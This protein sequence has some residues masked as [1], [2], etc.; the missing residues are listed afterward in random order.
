MDAAAIGGIL[1]TLAAIGLLIAMNKNLRM[2]ISLAVKAA[3]VVIQFKVYERK[4][5]KGRRENPQAY[6]ALKAVDPWMQRKA[7]H[8]KEG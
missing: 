1:G 8:H 3:K 5:W 4:V 6:E 7:K 2:Q